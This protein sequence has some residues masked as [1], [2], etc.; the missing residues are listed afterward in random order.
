MTIKEMQIRQELIKYFNNTLYRNPEV[1]KALK[2]DLEEE[3]IKEYVL[4]YNEAELMALETI[5][6]ISGE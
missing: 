3:Y 4:G 6:E 1:L 2:R 5:K